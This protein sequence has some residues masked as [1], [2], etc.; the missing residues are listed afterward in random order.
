M[1]ST[2]D[3]PLVGFCRADW[4]SRYKTQ[5]TIH[6]DYEGMTA[7]HGE[8]TCNMQY[9][10]ITGAFTQRLISGG[11]LSA[12]WQG[13]TP[14]IYIDVKTTSQRWNTTF[15][16]SRRKYET[17]SHHVV[18]QTATRGRVQA[19]TVVSTLQ[20][21]QLSTENSVHIIFRVFQLYEDA[22]DFK[23]YVD[24]LETQ[25]LQ[26]SADKYIVTPLV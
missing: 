2:L 10:D 12:E 24:P 21:R 25:L 1:L 9:N 18:S 19:L 15:N 14:M 13:R 26:F 8:Q 17:V 23:V 7:G 5:V 22:I 20:M 4:T 6:P 16:I 3:P 11:Y